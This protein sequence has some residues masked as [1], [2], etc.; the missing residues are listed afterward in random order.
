MLTSP[1]RVAYLLASVLLLTSVQTLAQDPTRPY[2][3]Q[4]GRSAGVDQD[5]NL[6]LT[7]VVVSSDSQRALINNQWLKPGDTIAGY[8]VDGIG[9]NQVVLRSNQEQRVLKLFQPLN[10]KNNESQ[11]DQE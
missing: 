5:M 11:G 10:I 3:W 9:S 1:Y 2:G 6:V 7:Q 4:S 8:Q